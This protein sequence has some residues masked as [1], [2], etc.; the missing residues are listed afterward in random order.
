MPDIV[1]AAKGISGSYIPLSMTACSKE[2]LD[3]FEDKPLGWGSTYQAHPV[4]MAAGYESVKHLLKHDIVGHVQ[5]LA[6]VFEENMQRLANRHPCIKQYRAI[7]LFG[8]FD[9]QDLSG[10]NPKLQH[11]VAHAA[12]ATY[13]RAYNDAGLVGLHR[14]PHVHCAPPLIITQAEL[15]DGF[16]RLDQSLTVL[17][18]A[19]NLS[20]PDSDRQ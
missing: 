9:V 7:G 19:L 1:T 15:L 20:H 10:G 14:Y 2:I 8:C 13:K 17:D 18:D 4:A 12:F 6:P 5:Q 11:E 3:F 16:N